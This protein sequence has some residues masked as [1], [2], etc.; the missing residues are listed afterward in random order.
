MASRRIALFLQSRGNDYQQ[1]LRDDCVSTASQRAFTVKVFFA[2]G[3]A[4]RQ[5]EQLR[6]AL[7]EPV[8]T[9]A[10][11]LIVS[12]VQE[13]RLMPLVTEALRSRVGWIVLSRWSD[14]L[15]AQRAQFGNVPVFCVMPDH[16]EIGRI[17]ALQFKALLPQ[18]GEL[19]YIRGPLG[20]FSAERRLAG[21]RKELAGSS[22]R[23][24]IFNGDW[25]S[26]SG[27]RA[28]E[29]WI[30]IFGGRELPLCVVGSQNDSMA[31]GA[32]EALL[33]AVA[34]RKSPSTMRFALTGCDGSPS[35]GKRLVAEGQLAATVVI[36]S[37]SGRAVTELTSILDGGAQPPLAI[38]VDVKGYPDVN[39]LA[40]HQPR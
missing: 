26:E 25:S 12:P 39:V 22:L 33:E 24:V 7:R 19:V 15:S 6:E 35:Y 10:T 36:P 29:N 14:Y 1:L 20:T 4:D 8:T 30:G 18:G 32:R 13:S 40:K 9:R 31:V 28:I 16:E 2:E 27:A 23:P 11:A 34:T 21:V 5:A 38:L 3:D 17:Q 37:V